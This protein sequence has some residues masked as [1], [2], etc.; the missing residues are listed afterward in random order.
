MSDAAATS[1]SWPILS[2]LERRLLG[3]LIEKQKTTPDVYPLSL[4]GLV[5]GCNQKSNRDPL[6]TVEGHEVEETLEGLQQKAL[7]TRVESG[8][9]DKWRH[10][11]YEQWTISKVEIA[12]LAELLLRGPQTEGDLRARVSRMEPVDDLEAL[13]AVCRPLADRGLVVYLTPEGRRGTMLTHGFH[14]PQE[15]DR[16]RSRAGAA[17][18]VPDAPRPTPA[19]NPL[20]GRVDQLQAE[21]AELRKFIADLQQDLA[22]TRSQLEA[23]KAIVNPAPPA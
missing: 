21:T 15:L 1:Q 10:L 4:N 22:D 20:A 23:L 7:A 9:V 6:M 14:D 19:T 12:V 11:L 13:R 8:R 18:S 3:V 5:T 17:D 16:L 2:A